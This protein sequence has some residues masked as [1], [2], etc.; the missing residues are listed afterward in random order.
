[1]FNYKDKRWKHL[2]ITLSIYLIFYILCRTIL[3]EMYIFEWASRRYFM[4]SFLLVIIFSSLNKIKGA[5]IVSIGNIVSIVIAHFI[6]EYFHKYNISKVTPDMAEEVKYQLLSNDH[7]WIYL[8]IF[9]IF[10]CIALLYSLDRKS[11]TLEDKI[12]KIFI[13]ILLLFIIIIIIYFTYKLFM[14][15]KP[16]IDSLMRTLMG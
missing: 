4:Y 3:S 11:K 14:I 15:Y 5:Y 16:W 1:M 9:G 2:L 13:W 10:V 6:G 8:V 12:Y 7:W